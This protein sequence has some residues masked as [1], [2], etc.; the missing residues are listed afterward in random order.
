[1][2]LGE[3]AEFVGAS[4]GIALAALALVVTVAVFTA[5]ARMGNRARPSA[6]KK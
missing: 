6:D 2:A 5:V 3:I 1:M 4:A